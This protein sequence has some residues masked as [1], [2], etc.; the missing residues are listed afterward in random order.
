MT[1]A[2][3]HRIRTPRTTTSSSVAEQILDAVRS[4]AYA[5]GTKLPSERQ[6]AQ[7]MGV[8]R[9]SVREALSALQ[10]AG[11][12]RTRVGDGTY[13]SIGE[14][15]RVAQKLALLRDEGIDFLGIW[16]ARN[17]IEGILTRYGLERATSSDIEVLRSMLADMAAAVAA[18]DTPSF[19]LSDVAFHLAIADLSDDFALI[20]AEQQLLT[21]SRQFY[22]ALDQVG[23]AR[24]PSQ[25]ERSLDAHWAIARAIE[26][27]DPISA[28]SALSDHFAMIRDYVLNALSPRDHDRLETEGPFV[29][30]DGTDHDSA[31]D[32]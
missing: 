7:L 26:Q 25:L 24:S 27:R 9:N 30:P 14:L 12:V 22:R 17:E 18:R 28:E 3:F 11:F 13:V 10:I 20:R 31:A 1:D 32:E 21:I 4:G 2:D 5:D 19:S 23:S 6:L 29:S 8:S 16:G 15:S